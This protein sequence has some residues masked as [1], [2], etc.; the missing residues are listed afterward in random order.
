MFLGPS[1]PAS[2]FLGGRLQNKDIVKRLL[3]SAT[4][5]DRDIHEIFVDTNVLVYAHDADAGKKHLTARELVSQL[6]ES[7]AG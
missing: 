2:G 3:Y 7:R 6:W 1:R 4:L 5:D